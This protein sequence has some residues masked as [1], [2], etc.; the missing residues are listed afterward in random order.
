MCV[1]PVSG[2]ALLAASAGSTFRVPRKPEENYDLIVEQSILFYPTCELRL[3][4]AHD[5]FGVGALISG[6]LK[7]RSLPKS[8]IQSSTCRWHVKTA[9]K[10]ETVSLLQ[11]QCDWCHINLAVSSAR[12]GEAWSMRWDCACTTKTATTRATFTTMGTTLE[13]DNQY[14]SRQRN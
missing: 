11:P 5:D 9:F 1:C 7:T 12:H 14:Q 4:G 6:S 3:S 10:T 13:N 2:A 8:R